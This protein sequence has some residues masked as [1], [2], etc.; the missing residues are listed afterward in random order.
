MTGAEVWADGPRGAERVAPWR[1]RAQVVL[2]VE[3]AGCHGCVQLAA[4]AVQRAAWWAGWG[5][6]LLLLCEGPPLPVP[7]HQARDPRGRTRG[8]AD[9]VCLVFDRRGRPAG[10]WVLTHPHR[11]P[12][13]ELD[14]LVRWVGVQEPECGTCVVEPAWEELDREESA[15]KS[16]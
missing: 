1:L 6:E 12:W 16:T 3:G 9:A 5:V 7:A 13:E 2:A 10:R 15:W 11:L 8:G 4:E 14:A